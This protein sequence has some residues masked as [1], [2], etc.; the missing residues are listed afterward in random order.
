MEEIGDGM[1]QDGIKYPTFVESLTT[2]EKWLLP[3]NTA[4]MREEYDH[5]RSL[6][7]PGRKELEQ[8][9]RALPLPPHEELMLHHG[10]DK[11]GNDVL[12]EKNK[13]ELR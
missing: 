11:H 4:T 1:L 3:D 10:L 5:K 13:W 12:A 2:E 6:P 8:M 7:A 9:R